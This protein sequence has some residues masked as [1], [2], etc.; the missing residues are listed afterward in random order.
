MT[1]EY[2]KILSAAKKI[3]DGIVATKPNQTVTI[4]KVKGKVNLKQIGSGLHN[5]L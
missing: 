3:Q 2:A 4:D 1:E 5:R